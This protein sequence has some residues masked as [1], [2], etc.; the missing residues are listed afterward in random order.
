[1]ATSRTHTQD[2][3]SRLP[4]KQTYGPGR[5]ETED[6]EDI[7]EIEAGCLHFYIRVVDGTIPRWYLLR[8]N[9]EIC[10]GPSMCE[11]HLASRSIS[12]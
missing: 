4:A 10:D 6:I 11:V 1:M 12:D 3:A 7:P 2:D 5:I 9:G 8:S